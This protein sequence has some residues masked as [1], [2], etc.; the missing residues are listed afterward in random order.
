MIIAGGMREKLV[1]YPIAQGSKPGTTLTNWSVN[2]QLG[3]KNTPL[4]RR[5]DW[6]RLGRRDELM[7][8]VRRFSIPYL[9]VKGLIEGTPEFWEYPMCD[10]DPLPCWVE[11]RVAL[12]GDA[13]HPM[14]PVGSN[15]AGQAILDADMLAECLTAEKDIAAAFAKYQSVRLPLTAEV[16]RLNR[17]GGP[18]NVIDV[19]ENLAPDGFN[20]VTDVI[21]R[22]ELAKIVNGYAAVA[23]FSQ[24]QV[25]SGRGGQAKRQAQLSG[26]RDGAING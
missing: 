6:S 21:S 19:I 4:P 7:P 15:G 11:G 18:E 17:S 26:L 14:Y 13:A 25:N 16:V 12:L 2:V 23:G 3:D 9:D 1:V 8:H 22:E 20:K 24:N 10:R 5:E